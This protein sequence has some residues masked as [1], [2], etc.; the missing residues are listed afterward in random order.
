MVEVLAAPFTVTGGKVATVEAGSDVEAAQLLATLIRTRP[1]E[2]A[3][4]PGFGI[5]DPTFAGGLDPGALTAAVDLYG[6]DRR[7]RTVTSAPDPGD[8]ERIRVTVNYD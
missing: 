7:V 1:G 5:A 2:R 8:P 6:P 4:A 3:A